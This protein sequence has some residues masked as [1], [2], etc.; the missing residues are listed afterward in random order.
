M[1]I[2]FN[3]DAK[4]YLLFNGEIFNR[5]NIWKELGETLNFQVNIVNTNLKPS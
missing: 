1:A 3:K 5:L 4:L 2:L